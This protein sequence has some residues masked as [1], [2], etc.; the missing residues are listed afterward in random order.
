MIIVDRM[1]FIEESSAP[2]SESGR[3][4]RGDEQEVA[5]LMRFF[6]ILATRASIES[7]SESSRG[8]IDK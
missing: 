1:S 3:N 8:T 4:R 7:N 5:N 6:M 2:Y